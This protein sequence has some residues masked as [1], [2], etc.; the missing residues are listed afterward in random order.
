MTL[1]FLAVV[2]LQ[3]GWLAAAEEETKE[4]DC[5]VCH[6]IISVFSETLT[7]EEK[8][9]MVTIEQKFQAFCDK[10]ANE[11]SKDAKFCYYTTGASSLKREISKPLSAGFPPAAICKKLGKKDSAI[12]A[13]TYRKVYTHDLTKLEEPQ[14]KKMKLKDLR[15]ILSEHNKECVGCIEKDDFVRTVLQIK[16]DFKPEGKAEL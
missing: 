4:P 6:N 1:A 16:A 13:L 12:C 7:K 9:D 3:A 8:K 10:K 11:N 14:I 2:C 15:T 5:P